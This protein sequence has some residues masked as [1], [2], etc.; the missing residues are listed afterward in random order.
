LTALSIANAHTAIAS[1]KENLYQLPNFLCGHRAGVMDG[2]ERVETGIENE[3]SENLMADLWLLDWPQNEEE[4]IGSYP[5]R[6]M[7]LSHFRR[8]FIAANP[9]EK[10]G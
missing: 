6:N 8:V 5:R 10:L 1:N 4:L 3:D 2:A 9:Q 7:L